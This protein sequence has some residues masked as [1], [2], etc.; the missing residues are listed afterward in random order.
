MTSNYWNILCLYLIINVDPLS[1]ILSGVSNLLIR[2]IFSNN[3]P[4]HL[5]LVKGSIWIE[6]TGS[7]EIIPTV[8]IFNRE[9]FRT[10]QS[11]SVLSWGDAFRNVPGACNVTVSYRNCGMSFGYS[12][13]KANESIIS[14]NQSQSFCFPFKFFHP[15]K[16]TLNKFWNDKI[17]FFEF[18]NFFHVFLRNYRTEILKAE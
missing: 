11:R 17:F 12:C 6:V 7:N 14:T 5:I 13:R 3:N 2:F 16:S 1:L 15:S 18:L 9:W 10:K 4:N 8:G